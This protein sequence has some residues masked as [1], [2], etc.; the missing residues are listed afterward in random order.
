[1]RSV[2]HVVDEKRRGRS[3]WMLAILIAGGVEAVALFAGAILI[4]VALIGGFT[5]DTAMAIFVL[6]FGAGMG[7]V[8]TI[9]L[10]NL[11]RGRRWAR[12]PLITWQFFQLAVAVPLLRGS[13]PW[14][15]VVLLLLALV[16]TVGMFTPRVIAATTDRSGPAAML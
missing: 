9:M 14:I 10:R 12:G 5:D 13:T 16:V 1:M 7:A 15:G 11:R 8:I 2:V 6:V 4:V 3:S